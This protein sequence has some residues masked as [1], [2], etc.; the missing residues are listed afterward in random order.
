MARIG[1]VTDSTAHVPDDLVAKYGLRIADLTVQFGQQSF[2]EHADLTPDEFFRRMKESRALPT[3]SQPSQGEFLRVYE[4]LAQDHDSIIVVTLSHKLSGTINSATLAAKEMEGRGVP[5]TV[6][7]SLSAW[8]GTGLQVIAGAQAAAEGHSHAECVALIESIVPRMQVLLVVDTL[9]NL[10]RGGRIGGATAFIGT[11]L[12]IKPVLTV[13]DGFVQPLERVRTRRKALE[14]IVEIMAQYVGTQP[15]T[16]AVGHALAEA[17]ADQLRANIL[18]RMPQAR[19]MYSSPVSPVV[20]VH[21]GPG[22]LG[23]V[24]YVNPPGQA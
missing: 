6:I 14:R 3:S 8:M 20:A 2:R 16:A 10:Q 1:F 24:Y 23:L 17:D 5:I 4:E 11:M 18:E 22:A 21:T 9:E 12:Q 7:D 15:Y 13:R 19:A